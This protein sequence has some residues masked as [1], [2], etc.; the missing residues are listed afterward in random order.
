QVLLSLADDV[1]ARGRPAEPAVQ[2][3]TRAGAPVDPAE[4]QHLSRRQVGGE[5][6]E[7]LA[8][9]EGQVEV[10][11]DAR[12]LARD[13][14]DHLLLA[15][16]ARD[17][18]VGRIEPVDPN[19]RVDQRPAAVHV[20]LALREAPALPALALRSLERAVEAVRDDL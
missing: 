4:L 5:W 7:Q 8:P 3:A 10:G 14:L 1:A 12:Q 16:G 18:V 6:P 13:R 17:V 20:L 2:C 15:L 19:P 9:R 11:A